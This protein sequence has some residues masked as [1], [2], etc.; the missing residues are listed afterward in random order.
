MNP[1]GYL[2]QL[3]ERYIEKAD[4]IEMRFL[5]THFYTSKINQSVFFPF[6]EGSLGLAWLL[7][8]FSGVGVPVF[9]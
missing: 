7:K 8:G 9:N 2:I 5:K 6:N 4:H 1:A 3:D